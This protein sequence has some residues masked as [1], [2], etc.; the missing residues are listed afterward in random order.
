MAENKDPNKAF[1]SIAR[2]A[3]R[4]FKE[5]AWFEVVVIE[6]SKTIAPYA[7]KGQVHIVRKGA[8]NLA[9]P[10]FQAMVYKTGVIVAQ[11][12]LPQ[13][14]LVFET[15]MIDRSLMRRV[16]VLLEKVVTQWRFN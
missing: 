10:Y 5:S 4:R 15:G 14:D 2:M 6:S 11:A 8:K 9:R 7:I 3:H 12:M 13:E 16:G 1:K